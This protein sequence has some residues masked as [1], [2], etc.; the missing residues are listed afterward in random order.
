MANEIPNKSSALGEYLIRKGFL[1]AEQWEIAQAEQKKTGKKITQILLHLRYVD[2]DA[3]LNFS[4]EQFKIP[5][6]VLRHYTIKPD[7]VKKLTEAQSRRLKA[8]ILDVVG[9]SYLVGMTDPGDLIAHDELSRMLRKK[10]RLAL[11]K[12]ADLFRVVDEVFHHSEQISTIA[13]ELNQEL[14]NVGTASL[15]DESAADMEAPVAKLLTSIFESAVQSGAS[16]I[17]IE[18]DVDLL[19]IRLRVDGVLREQVLKEKAIFPAL[20]LKLKLL[21][22]LNISEKRLPQDGRFQ[23]KVLDK[24]FD[25]RL[26]TLPIQYGES[27]VMRLL[28]RS[29]SSLKLSE[30]GMRPEHYKVLEHHI[31][32]PHGMI[33]LTGPTG[34]GKTT[35]LYACLSALNQAERKIITAEDPIEYSLSRINQVQIQSKVGLDFAVVLRAALRQDP[36]VVMVGEI[37]DQ[38]TAGIALKAAITGHLVF[39]TLHTNDAIGSALR[40]LDMGAEGYITATALRLI[41]AQ[42]LVRKICPDCSAPIQLSS[43]ERSYLLGLVGGKALEHTYHR[44]KGC[45]Q[46]NQTGYKG[47]LG[48]HEVLE[49][50]GLMVDALRAGDTLLFSKV[51]QQSPTYRPLALAAYDYAAEKMTTLDEVFRISGELEEGAGVLEVSENPP[52]EPP[53]EG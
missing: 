13:T 41:I 28:D 22:K 52:P 21:S 40:L 29:S 51:A 30:L 48:V 44:G 38:E 43:Q 2:E 27:V 42:R 34:S 26:S 36:D 47:R 25:V 8:I 35:T 50:T 10:I 53:L 11:V 5:Y 37:R 14:T 33:L 16:D 7:I 1:N 17:H 39:S 32:R 15:L 20:V 12:E 49:M 6:V 4:A 3:L 18:P 45:T 46:C 23:I 24:I 19:R 9:N 31:H